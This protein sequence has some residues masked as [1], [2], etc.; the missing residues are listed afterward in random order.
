MRFSQLMEEGL[1]DRRQI[2]LSIDDAFFGEHT[3]TRERTEDDT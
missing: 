2:R 3:G 1:E